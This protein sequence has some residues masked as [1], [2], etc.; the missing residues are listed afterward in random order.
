MGYTGTADFRHIKP[1]DFAR[2]WEAVGEDPSKRDTYERHNGKTD[3]DILTI[4]RG[5]AV[6][7]ELLG[8][9][10]KSFT[11][12]NGQAGSEFQLYITGINGYNPDGS[13]I[14]TAHPY[15]VKNVVIRSTE[16]GDMSNIVLYDVPGFDSTTELHKT[17]TERMLK[18]ADAIILVTNVGDRPNINSPQLDMLRKVRD[19]DGVKLR[20][21]TF[22]FGNK[23]DMAGNEQRAK[24][25]DSALRNEA[26]KFQ[27]AQGSRVISGSAKAYLESRGLFSEDEIRRGKINAK[28]K[29]DEWGM[30]DGITELHAQLQ[31]YYDNDRF[32]VLRRRAEAAITETVEFL[33]TLLAKYSPEV[34]NTFETGGKY[35]LQLKGKADMFSKE[36]RDISSR[37]SE[38]IS[39]AQPF[40]TQLAQ[41]I[42][43]I[44]PLTGELSAL[45]ED[46]KRELVGDIDRVPQLSA[47][48]ARIRE[49][50]HML[51]MTNLVREAAGIIKDKQAEIRSELVKKFLAVMGMK[52]G[53]E[54]EKD[55]TKSANALFDEYLIKDGEECRFNTLIER[56]ASGLV[57]T[58]ILLPFAEYERLDKVRRTLPELFSLAVY[59]SMPERA[60]DDGT[61]EVRDSQEDR[62]RFFAAILAHEGH[63]GESSQSGAEDRPV[64]QSDIFTA[65]SILI[66]YFDRNAKAAGLG[67]NELPLDE[68]AKLFAQS[69]KKF[70]AMPGDLVK[71]LEAKI[72][73][74][75]WENLSTKQRITSLEA[76]IKAY[77]V[78]EAPVKALALDELL[79]SLHEKASGLKAKSID[80]MLR[81]LDA[82]IEIL[83]D[84]TAKSVIRAIGLERAFISIIVKNINFI[85]RGITDSGDGSSK[86]DE[87][88]NLN[89]RKAMDSEFAAIDRYNMDSQTRKSIVAAIQQ[90]LG[91]ME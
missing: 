8:K 80:D 18:E 22:V 46:A 89:V 21:K 27:V 68:W 20:D 48:N 71:A 61:F 4:L 25:N 64:K 5:S 79:N 59:Y 53:S 52:E 10:A 69:G 57:D 30:S 41:S 17:Q 12:E 29:L 7:S 35:M 39:T 9:P 90:V 15:A 26:E 37:Y 91:S 34:L 40:S 67:V 1:E 3:E 2:Y 23:I 88:I 74:A 51:F 55:L 54:F 13:A 65:K 36:A 77:F 33:R 6:I 60:G 72:Y 16:L 24:G 32:E 78:S 42:Q 38:A 19:Q 45:I 87:W 81:I 83:R 11:W 70:D 66:D 28:A 82:D 50:V 49:K 58:L 44:Y 43:R 63:S 47:I 85:R 31:T 62:V 84:L 14:R 73:K 75:G 86:F 56:F 76:T